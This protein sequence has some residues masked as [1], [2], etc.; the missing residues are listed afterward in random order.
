MTGVHLVNLLSDECQRTILIIITYCVKGCEYGDHES[1]CDQIESRECYFE[2]TRARCCATCKE[3]ETKDPG[4]WIYVT[5]TRKCI[6]IT[7]L[8]RKMSLRRYF[9]QLAF[10]S[11]ERHIRLSA[12]LQ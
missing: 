5:H 10:D 11:L 4:E 9:T 6:M 1:T 12:R 2:R 8:L 7:P 3:R